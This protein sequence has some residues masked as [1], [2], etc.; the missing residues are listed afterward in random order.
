MNTFFI[1]PLIPLNIY[2]NIQKEKYSINWDQMEIK[3]IN[4]INFLFD[5]SKILTDNDIKI[6]S[7]IVKKIDK[8]RKSNLEDKLLFVQQNT[9]R[10]ITNYNYIYF[11]L[12]KSRNYFQ[13]INPYKYDKITTS[14]GL[15]DIGPTSDINISRFNMLNTTDKEYFIDQ[16]LDGVEYKSKNVIHDIMSKSKINSK[17]N[18]ITRILS[19]KSILYNILSDEDY[20]PFSL[21]FE[22]KHDDSTLNNIIEEFKKNNKS[23]YFVIKPSNGT[24]SDGLAIK[25]KSELT[26]E[27]IREWTINPDN[28]KYSSK[29]E[30]DNIY[31][32]WILSSFIKSF[33]WKLN[34]PSNVSI[35]FPD[36]KELKSVSFND[37]IGRINKFRFYCLWKIIDGKF[38]SY[39]YKNA[40]TEISLEELT[41]YSKTQLDPSN[42]EEFYQ[43][44]LNVTEDVD[45]F[46]QIQLNGA[47]TDNEKKIEAATVGTYL[48]F[49]Y[50]VNETNY[51]PGKDS[52]NKVMKGM[53]NILNSMFYKI[54]RYLNCLNKYSDIKDSGCFSYFALDILID[55]DN[56]PWLLEANSRPFIG[57]SN[58]WN[59]YDANNEHSVNVE[60][61]LNTVISLT[62]DTVNSDG[63]KGNIDDFLITIED[64]TQNYK[65]V[66]IPFTLGLKDNNT[67][68]IYDEMYN[69]LDNNDYSAFPYGKYA[70]SGVGFRG[71]S[72]ISKYLISRIDSMGKEYTISLLRDLYPYDTKQKILNRITTLGFYLGDK[73]EL[74]KK[75]KDNNNNWESII[76]WTIIYNKGDSEI[77]LRNKLM[78]KN[79]TFICKPSLG[80]Q[81]HGIFINNDLDLIISTI[82]NSEYDSWIISRYLDNPYLIKLNKKGVSDVIYN[83]TIG[84]KCH[85]RVYVL[86]NKNKNKLDVYLYK[87]NLI[88]CASKEYNTCK[89]ESI[90]SE[91][92]NLTNLYYGG[93]YYN[94]ILRKDP[95]D[96]YK[97]LSG[98]TNELINPSEYVKLMK[99]VKS[100]VQKTILS[101]KNDL[102]CLNYN[103]NC[104]QYIAFDFHLENE[105]NNEI[106]PWLLEVN[107]TPGLKAPNYQFKDLGG[108]TNYLESIFNL[109][110]N[111][112]FSKGNKQLF[113]FISLKKNYKD[114]HIISELEKPFTDIYSCMYNYTY[115]QLKQILIDKN[116]PRR[117]KLT[118]KNKMCKK[119][120]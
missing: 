111:T 120:I 105:N 61:F 21:S 98:L 101:V 33:L 9:Y 16:L 46:E 65:K 79:F 37:N 62:I 25:P 75:I 76:P 102:V 20:I 58:W 43:N 93:K 28:N 39:I 113:D 91:Y 107:S 30:N 5:Y 89:D 90:P 51:P 50:T 8:L 99:Q 70:P 6:I 49:A 77:D 86:L 42:I 32:T 45:V 40:Y 118:T 38:T 12:L 97:D 106:R 11:S 35:L 80:Q 44:I 85:L 103:N 14:I 3:L 110:L 52:W 34:R 72:S 56:K 104:F 116:I 4:N 63:I 82:S 10:E 48:D 92:C 119:L 69:I 112:D 53:Y 84:R 2:L 96:A 67:N 94:D 1:T 18:T 23:E 41:T 55:S 100:L 29:T 109:T 115:T 73:S 64:F 57:F 88:F 59:K 66:Y 71:M 68:K 26:V 24:L 7:N 81:G 22:L 117:S 78:N 27:F 95:N 108:I 31:S 15:S 60:S 17:I 87:K 13:V 36:I 54:K 74:T 114:S 19:N 83:D 47:K